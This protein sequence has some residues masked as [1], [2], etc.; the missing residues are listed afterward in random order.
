MCTG[1]RWVPCRCAVLGMTLANP[2][3]GVAARVSLPARACTAGAWLRANTWR[4]KGTA[5]TSA[6]WQLS[7]APH[8]WALA[9]TRPIDRLALMFKT[10][11]EDISCVLT[12]LF[13]VS[14]MLAVNLHHIL[15]VRMRRQAICR[16]R[17]HAYKTSMHWRGSAS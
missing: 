14:A 16:M 8:P 2:Q 5:P 3:C 6:T 12:I 10:S 1:R 17:L 13:S 9:A 15:W 11:P 7:C 4:Q